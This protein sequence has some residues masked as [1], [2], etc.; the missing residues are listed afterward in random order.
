MRIAEKVHSRWRQWRTRHL[1]KDLQYCHPRWPEE[2]KYLESELAQIRTFQRTYFREPWNIFEWI[3][4]FVILTLVLTRILS[5][6]SHNKTAEEIHPRIYALGLIVI[7]LRFM[8]SCRAFRSLGPFI[9]ILGSVIS[10]TMKFAFLFFEFFIPYTVG[11]W[12]LFGGSTHAKTMGE[13]AENW[14]EFNDL[15]FS[16]WSVSKSV[17]YFAS[18]DNSFADENRNGF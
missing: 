4:Y 10:D 15:T 11:F 16:V 18:F 6:A 13:N 14:E 3:A 8:R 7:W 5:V 17:I 9:A 2:R 1:E 12:I